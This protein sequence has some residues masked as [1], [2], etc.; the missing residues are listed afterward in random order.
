MQAESLYCSMP[1]LVL[2]I[3]DTVFV[4]QSLLLVEISIVLL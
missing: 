4:H 3:S 2:V 1:N